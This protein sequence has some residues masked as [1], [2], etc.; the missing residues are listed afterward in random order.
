M[1]RRR[2][3]RHDTQI[4]AGTTHLVLNLDTRLAGHGVV[5]LEV[6]RPLLQR[7]EPEGGS[8][9]ED[10]DRVDDEEPVEDDET[11]CDMVLL[12]DCSD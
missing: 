5:D 2:R 12:H 10:D 3:E 8:D 4:Q 7:P 1:G 6:V 9:D 11:A